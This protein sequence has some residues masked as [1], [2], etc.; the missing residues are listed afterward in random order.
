[1][2]N[3]VENLNLTSAGNAQAQLP[4]RDEQ[5]RAFGISNIFNCVALPY[6]TL[7]HRNG[8]VTVLR[9]HMKV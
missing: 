6:C 5:Q 4:F 9:C 3:F 2:G 1:M 7:H 8:D